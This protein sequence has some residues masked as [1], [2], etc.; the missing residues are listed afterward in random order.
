MTRV[1]CVIA[2]FFVAASVAA[3]DRIP[4]EVLQGRDLRS[5]HDGGVYRTPINKERVTDIERLRKF[6]WTHWTQKRR[7]YVEIV[8]QGTDSGTEAYL[9]I[10]PAGGR[11]RIAW[12][13]SYYYLGSSSP[14]PPRGYRDIVTVERCR[15]SLVFFD[16]DNDIV[17]YL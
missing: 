6:V 9:F 17:K 11:W 3:A 4:P 14:P 15:G 1:C 5:Y 8:F 7:G 16:A 2:A 13:E 12:R 10:E